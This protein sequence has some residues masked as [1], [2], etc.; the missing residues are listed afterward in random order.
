MKI[1]T[2][3]LTICLISTGYSQNTELVEYK[4]ETTTA[5][6]SLRVSCRNSSNDPLKVNSFIESICESTVYL[7][8]NPLMDY[9]V[10][11]NNNLIIDVD[12]ETI[13]AYAEQNATGIDE[14]AAEANWMISENEMSPVVVENPFTGLGE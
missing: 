7:R 1:I 3:L 10:I 12:S 9:E 5:I 8:L 2:M 6:Q 11:V 14:N 4:V 13:M